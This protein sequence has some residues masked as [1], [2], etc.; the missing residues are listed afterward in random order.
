M[1]LKGSSGPLQPFHFPVAKGKVTLSGSVEETVSN[2]VGGCDLVK[3]GG[4]GLVGP[5]W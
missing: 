3:F 5:L 1:S 4:V 2:C